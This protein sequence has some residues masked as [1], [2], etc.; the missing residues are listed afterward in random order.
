MK[1]IIKHL[2]S[3]PNPYRDQALENLHQS[4]GDDLVTGPF[5]ALMIGFNWNL[6]PQG[7][8]YWF[9]FAY[10]FSGEPNKSDSNNYELNI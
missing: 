3:L 4:L 6:T 2:K 5:E 10:Q 1:T 9:D 8:P 7:A